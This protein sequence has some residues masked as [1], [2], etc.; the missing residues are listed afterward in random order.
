[1]RVSVRSVVT[2]RKV[3]RKSK[4][5]AKKKRPCYVMQLVQEH[6]SGYTS[7]RIVE[8]KDGT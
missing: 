4:K 6:Q 1:M 8:V 2:L 5:G 7:L 3:R